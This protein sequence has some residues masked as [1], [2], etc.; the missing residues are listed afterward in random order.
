[1]SIKTINKDLVNKID[2]YSEP[3]GNNDSHLYI[4]GVFNNNNK[5]YPKSVI[6]QIVRSMESKAVVLQ[7]TTGVSGLGSSISSK[8]NSFE[9]MEIEGKSIKVITIID[10]DINSNE[11]DCV[12]YYTIVIDSNN[13]KV[14][15]IIC[16]G[17]ILNEDEYIWLIN[18]LVQVYN[19]DLEVCGL[20][21]GGKALGTAFSS[22]EYV[23]VTGEV[24]DICYNAECSELEVKVRVEDGRLA[25][26]EV[27]L[28]S[29][30]GNIV[31]AG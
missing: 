3:E 16:K 21:V 23:K 19:I 22:G 4:N 24:M 15:G 17:D 13:S 20:K 7:T 6:G 2:T 9:I 12:E 28:N 14:R 26:K 8:G 30:Y 5:L 25:G 31:V 10:V 11:A 1:M 18:K 29:K 27:L